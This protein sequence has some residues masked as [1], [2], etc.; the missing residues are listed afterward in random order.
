VTASDIRARAHLPPVATA[1]MDGVAIGSTAPGEHQ[2]LSDPAGSLWIAAG[3]P[4][5]S[6]TAAIV[7][8]DAP[9]EGRVRVTA[10][11]VTT[12][13][14][15]VGEDATAGD[16]LVPAGSV[17]THRMLAL[18]QLAGVTAITARRHADR[19]VLIGDAASVQAAQAGLARQGITTMTA[20]PAAAPTAEHAAKA[21]LVL[22]VS[23]GVHDRPP[24]GFS[25]LATFQPRA[26]PAKPVTLGRIGADGPPALLIAGSPFAVALAARL[27]VPAV[28][29]ARHGGALPPLAWPQA[30]AGF[31]H[32]GDERR[33]LF[34]PA[35]LATAGL[36][37]TVTL[38]GPS[39][40][41]T[42]FARSDGAVLIPVGSGPVTPGRLLP[43]LIW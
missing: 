9:A 24:T 40:H 43:V 2:A 34:L 31:H 5:P 13:I 25:P 21:A 3:R 39:G 37:T 41:A 22:V 20:D 7:R 42:A 10:P 4:V 1:V 38:A 15:G 35:R 17:L 14:R 16:L 8:M 33:D 19:I 26:R 30:V 12:N 32:E 27:H 23:P 6:G 29:Q 28:L 18:L 11:I 36:V